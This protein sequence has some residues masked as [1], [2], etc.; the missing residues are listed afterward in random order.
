MPQSLVQVYVHLVFSTKRRQPFLQDGEFR[1]RTH[2]YLAGTLKNLNCPA[3]AVGGTEDHVHALCRLG[4][5][6]EIASLIRDLKRDSSKWV[7]AEQPRLSDFYWQ[8]G[9]G[10]LSISPAHVDALRQYIANQEEHHRR[11]SFQDELRR[12]CKKYGLEIDERYV[13]D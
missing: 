4:Q 2:R 10:A 3:L 9:Y 12:L 7:K 6:V 11:E 1:D 13:W 5:N 8:G